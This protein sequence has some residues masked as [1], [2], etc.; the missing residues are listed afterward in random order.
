MCG[1]VIRF[2]YR[3]GGW[4]LKRPKSWFLKIRMVPN[5]FVEFSPKKC[6]FIC[7]LLWNS[8]FHWRQDNFIIYSCVW[9]K[10]VRLFFL[11][12]V[13]HFF[14]LFSRRHFVFP[15]WKMSF[16]KWHE[17]SFFKC[18]EILELF[19]HFCVLTHCIQGTFL[20]KLLKMCK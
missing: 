7:K 1:L 14:S 19:P 10:G 11:L 18:K 2:D 4:V 20:K 5:T 3:L 6:G 9:S 12:S 15:S 13:S 16:K 8:Q 17:A